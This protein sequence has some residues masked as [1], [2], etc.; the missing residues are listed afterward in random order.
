MTEPRRF[1]SP[2]GRI[3]RRLPTQG[4]MEYKPNLP[5][6]QLEQAKFDRQM[7]L[8]YDAYLLAAEER[9]VASY[10]QAD[11]D[12][13]VDWWKRYQ[14]DGM[15]VL[16]NKLRGRANQTLFSLNE[17]IHPETVQAMSVDPGLEQPLGGW[18]GCVR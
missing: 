11:V 1:Q 14:P 15:P 2:T 5:M 13:T 9:V 18:C 4:L 16:V 3:E 10:A 17:L 8:Y 7:A 12:Y 6:T